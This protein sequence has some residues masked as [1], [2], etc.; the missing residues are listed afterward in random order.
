MK[1]LLLQDVQ[2]LGKKGDICEV[3]DGYGKNFLIAKGLADFA[4][5]AVINRYKAEQKRAAQLVAQE[6]ALMEMAAKKIGEVTLKIAQKVGAN[7]SLYGAI[8]K[9]H[10]AEALAKEHRLEIDKK[11]IELKNP[12]KSTGVYEV[13][14]K[15]GYGICGIL[16]IDVEAQ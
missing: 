10:I 3:K 7:G 15:L 6:K 8:T 5:N 1:I 12:I 11:T 9:E 14:I 4:T 16:K 2:G 13:E